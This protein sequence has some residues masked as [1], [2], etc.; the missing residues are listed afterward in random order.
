MTASGS[1]MI[2]SGILFAEEGEI[3]VK[4][5]KTFILKDGRS[6]IVRNGTEQ[7]AEDVLAN[8]I[9]THAQTDFLTTYPDE[10]RFTVDQEKDYLK[11][12]TANERAV[13]LVAEVDGTITGTAGVDLIREADKTRHRACFGISIDK[14]WWGLGIGRALTEAAVECAKEAGYLQL[15][16]E[17]VADNER[18][19][20]LYQRAGFVEFGRNPRGFRTRT[21]N[22]QELV[23]MR[24]ELD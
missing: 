13:E 15:E 18:A 7:D 20:S 21:G 12:K 3:P 10:T 19:L 4:Y 8:F 9:G 22:W 23:L 16:L 1:R 2:L 11:E 5:N 24:M 14:A 6:C 17:A